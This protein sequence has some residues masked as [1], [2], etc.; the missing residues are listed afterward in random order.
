MPAEGS[1]ETHTSCRQADCA[2]TWVGLGVG[3]SHLAG[4]TPPTAQES[5]SPKN[6][7]LLFLML[8]KGGTVKDL[9]GSAP[10]SS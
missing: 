6:L 10:T 5:I 7:L 4:L 2:R 8:L 1:W 3:R 9:G